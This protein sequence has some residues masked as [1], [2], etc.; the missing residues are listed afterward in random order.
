MLPTWHANSARF[1]AARHNKADIRTTKS[2]KCSRRPDGSPC[3]LDIETRA[4]ARVLSHGSETPRFAHPLLMGSH[5]RLY[6]GHGLSARSAVASLANKYQRGKG[7]GRNLAPF[8]TRLL[9][10][11]LLHLFL[12]GGLRGLPHT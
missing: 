6:L 5:K 3:N 2:T 10:L 7:M 8:L 9:P 12:L 4:R 11:G 1:A